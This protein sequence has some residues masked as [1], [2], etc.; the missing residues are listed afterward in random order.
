[1]GLPNSHGA[2]ASVSWAPVPRQW[3]HRR[4]FGGRSLLGGMR[5]R[6]AASEATQS[7]SNP[8]RPVQARQG[9]PGPQHGTAPNRWPPVHSQPVTAHGELP[10][11]SWAWAELR[12]PGSTT[13][14]GPAA[15]RGGCTPRRWPRL[16]G[17]NNPVQPGSE[18]AERTPGPGAGPAPLPP[19][20]R[21]RDPGVH[22]P[23]Y[24]SIR[25]TSAAPR[26][27]GVSAGAAAAGCGCRPARGP[28]GTGSL[29]RRAGSGPAAVTAQGTGPGPSPGTSA[30]APGENRRSSE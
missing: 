12:G 20:P 2:R 22:R 13:G 8:P 3:P 19:R 6:G 28:R 5:L 15:T 21:P 16:P 17:G 18:N 11:G 27:R 24:A 1:M 23:R 25:S 10:S 9:E 7:V 4:M 14:T 26:A 29:R 30:P